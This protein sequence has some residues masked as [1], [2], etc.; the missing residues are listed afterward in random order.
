MTTD[1]ANVSVAQRLLEERTRLELTQGALAE[2]AG[3]S[4]VSI[5]KYESGGTLPSA[6]ALIALDRSGVDIRY[7]LVGV[8]CT[9]S[10]AMRD[11]FRMAFEEVGRQAQANK[12]TLTDESRLELA[13]RIYEAFE[14][15]EKYKQN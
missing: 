11:R 13:W 3:L 9:G 1:E 14:T 10:R 15:F 5:A 7:V 12:E 6:E 2:L 8:Y 4:R